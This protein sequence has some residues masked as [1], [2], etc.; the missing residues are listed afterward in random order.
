VRI[1][2]QLVEAETGHH[3]WAD[4]FD[5]TLDDIFELQ[6]RVAE[7]VAGAIEP[8][9]QHAE[10][11][12]AEAKPTESLTAYDLYLRALPRCYAVTRADSAEAL[13]LL[14]RA[15]AADPNFALG[16]AL[17]A[18]CVLQ[19]SAQFWAS[20]DERPDG[21]RLAREALAAHKDD[22]ATLRLAGHAVALL[23]C[24]LAAGLAAATRALALNPNSGQV[25]LSAG[26]ICN[27]AARA[28]PALRHFERA[29]RLSPLDPDMVWT[30]SGMG[31]AYLIAGDAER[32]LEWG[33]RA[34]S[35]SPTWTTAFRVICAANWMLGRFDEARAAV[36]ENLRLAP[37]SRIGH[38]FD[39]YA[40]S[41]RI[42]YLN[43]LRSAGYPE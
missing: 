17:A 36:N 8:S 30:V 38:F 24:D 16:K 7:T 2:G 26:W 42:P 39:H 10:V 21:V 3:V 19:R 13:S 9:L 14:R 5:G 12:R 1:T 6:D 28:E 20:E 15:V 4:R 43:A 29:M 41:F 18:Y 31:M 11:L 37:N 32:A 40:E 35:I 25:A 23:G 34:R 27:Y 33:E 22:P